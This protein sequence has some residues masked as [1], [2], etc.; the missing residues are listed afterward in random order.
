M[1]LNIKCGF[2]ILLQFL[3]KSIKGLNKPVYFIIKKPI[4]NIVKPTLNFRVS[5]LLLLFVRAFI[6]HSN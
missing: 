1:Y 2:T 6:R 4:Q 5:V 3:K